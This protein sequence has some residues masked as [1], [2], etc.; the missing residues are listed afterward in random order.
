MSCIATYQATGN[1][2]MM[3][4]GQFFLVSSNYR[5][6]L[7]VVQVQKIPL[8]PREFAKKVVRSKAHTE[9]IDLF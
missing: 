7:Q 8:R 1:F 5:S 4:F 2:T 6:R 9:I 3:S